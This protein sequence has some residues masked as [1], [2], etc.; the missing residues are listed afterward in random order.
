MISLCPCSN[1]RTPLAT[2]NVPLVRQARSGAVRKV[3]GPAA[4]IAVDGCQ[5]TR[6]L[7]RCEAEVSV[8][9]HQLLTVLAA[10]LI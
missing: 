4:E 10:R 1:P 6:A 8:P 3:H 7:F 2:A 5:S 9:L